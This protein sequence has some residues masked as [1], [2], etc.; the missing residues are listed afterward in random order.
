MKRGMLLLFVL[1]I[2]SS[3]AIAHQPRI[4]TDAPLDNP[5]IV[6]NPEVSKAYYGELKGIEHNYKIESSKE[7]LFYINILAPDVKDARTDFIVEAMSP[8]VNVALLKGW[9]YDWTK[10]YDD[11]AGDDYLMGPMFEKTLKPGVYYVK[12]YNAQNAGKYSLTIGKKESFPPME[13]ARTLFTLPKI[14]KE[15]F[16]KS[17]FSAFFN[18]F[19]IF[20][21]VFILAIAG[22]VFLAY[23]IIRAKMRKKK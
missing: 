3:F 15:F 13:I 6:E 5:V 9:D 1:V 21:L 2:L 16:G 12:V 19:G 8:E 14:K 18:L 10:F 23:G 17:L 22:I 20:A 11:F 7:F 4:V